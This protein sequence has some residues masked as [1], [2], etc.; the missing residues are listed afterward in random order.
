MGLC[1]GLLGNVL[2]VIMLDLMGILG[3][4]VLLGIKTIPISRTSTLF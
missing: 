2:N 3:I 1:E 4:K